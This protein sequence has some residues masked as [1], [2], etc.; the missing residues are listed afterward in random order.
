MTELFQKFLLLSLFCAG[1]GA[2]ALLLLRFLSGLSERAKSN[3]LFAAILLPFGGALLSPLAK[4]FPKP[5]SLPREA[6]ALPPAIREIIAVPSANPTPAIPTAPTTN[7]T[8]AILPTANPL[9]AVD[10]WTVASVLWAAVAVFLLLRMIFS[11]VRLMRS[12]GRC[13]KQVQSEN[14]LAV[15]EVSAD[16]SP[17]LTGIF[18]GSVYLP[19]NRY[20]A[21]ERA[22]ALA[23]EQFHFARGDA[24]KRIVIS[25]LRCINW[26][27]PPLRIILNRL[28]DQLEYACDEA[29]TGSMD[30]EQRRRYGFMLLKTAGFS[31]DRAGFSVGLSR[32]SKALK[33]RIG[34]FMQEKKNFGTAAK[35]LAAAVLS[36]AAVSV[37]GI[38]AAAFPPE[39]ENTPAAA[40]VPATAGERNEAD[41]ES[42][43]IYGGTMPENE[44]SSLS[45][46]EAV[47]ETD[48]PIEWESIV[49][50]TDELLGYEE[51]KKLSP[52]ER[53]A[54]YNAV[55]S[56]H[57]HLYV[58][59]DELG[60]DMTLPLDEK[61][62]P[63]GWET[64][65]YYC[66]EENSNV[67]SAADGTVIYANEYGDYLNYGKT[68]VIEHENGC[69]SLYVPLKEIGVE[70][71]Q[72]VK[73]GEV[74][75]TLADWYIGEPYQPNLTF[76][77]YKDLEPLTYGENMSPR[78]WQ[79]YEYLEIAESEDNPYDSLNDYI[80]ARYYP[81]NEIGTESV[82][83]EDQPFEES[84]LVSA[85]KSVKIFSGTIQ[86][87]FD[88][89]ELY[90]E[91]IAPIRPLDEETLFALYR[92][93]GLTR[94]GSDSALIYQGKLVR[95]FVDGTVPG[96]GGF[97]TRYTYCN[98]SGEI[99][100][101][102]VWEKK[103]NG[104]G[105]YDPFGTL[106]AIAEFDPS[107]LLSEDEASSVNVITEEKKNEASPKTPVIKRRDDIKLSEILAEQACD[108]LD[109][110][111]MESG[112]SSAR[113]DSYLFFELPYAA[114]I[115]SVADGTV[116]F[117]E[118]TIVYGLTVVVK[119]ADG[120]CWGYAH[121]SADFPIASLGDTVKAGDVIGYTGATGQ[122]T[123]NSL[124]LFLT[125]NMF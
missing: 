30:R 78:L 73:K 96:E 41:R 58:Y 12:L 92:P 67:Y 55:A 116:V 51:M 74:I 48:E 123:G 32:P 63:N 56:Y 94:R 14:R 33:R 18:R 37:V 103:D 85:D 1:A 16:I 100:L 91:D 76:E 104:G 50:D 10:W 77:L 70:T 122:A 105:S 40:D 120:T 125:E 36:A 52:S 88:R 9:A 11:H 84:F 110:D 25:V 115:Y 26:L 108:P 5:P 45:A 22:M 17:F 57:F 29:V 46:V 53:K 87:A 60:L 119:S 71:G 81:Q 112:L 114:K 113:E 19:E 102:T 64:N 80:Y 47:N 31:A 2:A 20:S 90:S 118:Y 27:N 106:T 66:A 89:T 13:R 111:S 3:F 107:S 23:H 79:I 49:T 4:L 62:L 34:I 97:A 121:C 109:P 8:P 21:E 35:A 75:G 72:K 82:P 15:Y 24:F 42:A 93:F 38:S 65:T 124:E 101:R 28:S 95:W 68:V 83:R 6:A 59:P 7:P 61:Y 54:Y 44:T 99:D 43:A 69:A 98:Q 39:T 86:Q 117:S